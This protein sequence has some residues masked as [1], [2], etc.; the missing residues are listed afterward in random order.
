[1]DR[2]MCRQFRESLVHSRKQLAEIAQLQMKL[3]IAA[4]LQQG[5]GSG[6]EEGDFAVT[7]HAEHLRG[8][9]STYQTRVIRQID[10]AIIRI[11]NGT[12]GICEECGDDIQHA[13]LLA[14]PF[15]TFCIDCQELRERSL[16]C[17]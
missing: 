13:R 3:L 9:R 17:A 6:R 1:M 10:S 7:N 5:I 14:V 8:K 11:D 4:E 2:E 15:A 12:F 16:V